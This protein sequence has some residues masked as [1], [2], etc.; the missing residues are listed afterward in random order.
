MKYGHKCDGRTNGRTNGPI[1]I[2]R[3]RTK[4]DTKGID[5]ENVVKS[6]LV[7]T[8]Y[9][10]V[11]KQMVRNIDTSPLLHPNVAISH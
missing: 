11:H 2:V 1:Y 9:D 3:R 7:V 5:H 6:H 4:N 8:I 10:H